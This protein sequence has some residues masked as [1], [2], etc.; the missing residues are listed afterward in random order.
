MSVDGKEDP[1]EAEALSRALGR[2]VAYLRA[3]RTKLTQQEF[4]GAMGVSP[5]Y[6][7]RIEDGR[8]NLSLRT[9]ARLAKV[10]E[11]SLA[12]LFEGID[13]EGVP[14]TNREY[15]RRPDDVD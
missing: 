7:W 11:V 4:A 14:L 10:L 13:A 8:Q 2:R 12:E 3:E 15:M 9:L 5:A 1:A 6:L